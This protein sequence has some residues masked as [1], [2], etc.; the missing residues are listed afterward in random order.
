MF[1]TKIALTDPAIGQGLILESL[2]LE[3]DTKAVETNHLTTIFVE[4]EQ[5]MAAL[6]NIAKG[7]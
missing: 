6:M 4:Q 2:R 3:R 1:A 5:Y 7:I